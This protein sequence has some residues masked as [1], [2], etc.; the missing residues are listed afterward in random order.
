MLGGAGR[1]WLIR[2]AGGAM[3]H[4]NNALATADQLVDMGADAAPER[5]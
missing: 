1:Y 4:C 5:R 3:L 2:I